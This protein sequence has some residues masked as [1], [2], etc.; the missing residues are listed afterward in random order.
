[1]ELL[2]QL[3]SSRHSTIASIVCALILSSLIRSG[4]FSSSSSLSSPSTLVS[5]SAVCAPPTSFSSLSPKPHLHSTSPVRRF[6]FS[7]SLL[8]PTCRSALQVAGSSYP[9]SHDSSASILLSSSIPLQPI[10]SSSSSSTGVVVST[11]SRGGMS[12]VRPCM[13]GEVQ[14]ER[15]K[16]EEEKNRRDVEKEGNKSIR[17][18]QAAEAVGALPLLLALRAL[19][20]PSEAQLP[21]RGIPLVLLHH[22]LTP[23]LAPR[24]FRPLFTLSSDSSSSSSSS[25]VGP[26]PSSI[27]GSL[28]DRF[29][30]AQVSSRPLNTEETTQTQRPSIA[31]LNLRRVEEQGAPTEKG[32]YHNEPSPSLPSSSSSFLSSLSPQVTERHPHHADIQAFRDKPLSASEPC[33]QGERDTGRREEDEIG[34]GRDAFH[35]D[36][37]PTGGCCIEEM[38]VSFF[39][40]WLLALFVTQGNPLYLQVYRREED[41]QY[42]NLL[43][44]SRK[45][46]R[47]SLPVSSS[48]LHK[49]NR[50]YQGGLEFMG[51]S[52]EGGHSCNLSSLGSPLSLP[53]HL[54]RHPGLVDKSPRRERDRR[55]H[56][57]SPPLFTFPNSS[58]HCS[59]S[60]SSSPC[61]SITQVPQAVREGEPHCEITNGEKKKTRGPVPSLRFLNKS[62]SASSLDGEL[63]PK[64]VDH[65]ERSSRQ[66]MFHAATGLP[67]FSVSSLPRPQLSPFSFSS[68]PSLYSSSSSSSSSTSLHLSS[69]S[70]SPPLSSHLVPS[71]H[72]AGRNAHLSNER[73]G[74]CTGKKSEKQ[75]S[76]GSEKDLPPPHFHSEEKS[77]Y[78]SKASLRRKKDGEGEDAP[79]Q[80]E[81]GDGAMSRDFLLATTPSWPSKREKK[82]SQSLHSSDQGLYI[83]RNLLLQSGLV[84]ALVSQLRHNPSLPVRRLAA[85][86]LLWSPGWWDDAQLAS[87]ERRER[88]GNENRGRHLERSREELAMEC[89]RGDKETDST[90]HDDLIGKGREGEDNVKIKSQGEGRDGNKR[91]VIEEEEGVRGEQGGG[92]EEDR[93]SGREIDEGTVERRERAAQKRSEVLSRFDKS[94][95][96]QESKYEGI[97]DGMLDRDNDGLKSKIVYEKQRSFLETKGKEVEINSTN[98]HVNASTLPSLSLPPSS[99]LPPFPVPSS[100]DDSFLPS[101]SSSLQQLHP[102]H[103]SPNQCACPIPAVSLLSPPSSEKEEKPS[104]SLTG[105]SLS[106]FSSFSSSRLPL[107]VS[108]RV[109][110]IV[111]LLQQ[112]KE[113]AAHQRQRLR[114]EQEKLKRRQELVASRRGLL[115]SW[116][117]CLQKEKLFHRPSSSSSFSLL[118][119]RDERE[120]FC[121]ANHSS[122]QQEEGTE[123]RIQEGDG[124]ERR[125]GKEEEE[126]RLRNESTSSPSV[127]YGSGVGS[128]G[129]HR[130]DEVSLSSSCFQTSTDSLLSCPPLSQP[131]EESRLSWGEEYEGGSC[132]IKEVGGLER[133]IHDAHSSI[134]HSSTSTSSPSLDPSSSS[135][136]QRL[137]QANS[138]SPL[139]LRC[140]SSFSS[141]FHPHT[142]RER[143]KETSISC[144]PLR[145]EKEIIMSNGMIAPPKSMDFSGAILSSPRPM[146]EEEAEREQEETEE[147]RKE[148]KICVGNNGEGKHAV[149]KGEM[150]TCSREDVCFHVSSSQESS[151]HR[152]KRDRYHNYH[153]RRTHRRRGEQEIKRFLQRLQYLRRT[154]KVMKRKMVQAVSFLTQIRGKLESL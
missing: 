10:L 95:L 149:L 16:I 143:D 69:S 25:S 97:D 40:C 131:Q 152:E 126:E 48:G 24:F 63:P 142:S 22:L 85:L 109:S 9:S 127:P 94:D 60:P 64:K 58:P 8:S 53:F 150:P 45:T 86:V 118:H 89:N 92:D 56:S 2:A 19:K 100:P 20:K 67:C 101:S 59:S 83:T 90:T 46:R 124:E 103:P 55:S 62:F 96:A 107:V 73:E 144:S 122:A 39:L 51:A 84:C 11:S 41:Q 13:V 105:S 128:R 32:L 80:K 33:R 18:I 139:S 116:R 23:E 30:Q 15:E 151:L 137:Q 121:C 38:E 12:Y 119:K 112:T 6:P 125:E 148:E 34:Q 81:R 132:E 82:R 130:A 61:I 57:C 129:F 68:L 29:G 42:W 74:D 99:S 1:M 3:Y 78:L 44:A 98:T 31:P 71:L 88:E 47:G 65:R 123:R 14:E 106:P 77:T 72:Q 87:M 66:I 70:F 115:R 26:S 54:Y 91:Q 93:G 111:L 37:N 102:I 28:R 153:E 141:S 154:R 52:T 35:E 113:E 36:E 17:A 136:S 49:K 21:N 43:I 104:F 27:K 145:G 114:K 135:L 133:R 4:H 134:F 5:S 75:E 110:A 76:G 120:K 50:E 108:V 7:S 138:S 117:P 79:L 140:S 147:R 146:G